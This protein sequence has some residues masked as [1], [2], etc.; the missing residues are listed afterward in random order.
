MGRKHR[1]RK[2][3][4]HQGEGGRE[5]SGTEQGSVVVV[6]LGGPNVSA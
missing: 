5:G 1:Q 4:A 2:G 3:G 6:D